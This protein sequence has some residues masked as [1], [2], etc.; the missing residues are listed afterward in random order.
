MSIFAL[1]S[2]VFS[3]VA[4]VSLLFVLVGSLLLLFD[5][6]RDKVGLAMVKSGL[7]ALAI[8]FVVMVV[9]AFV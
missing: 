2:L 8:D 1:V 6:G 5:I 3:L 4:L 7:V 9:L